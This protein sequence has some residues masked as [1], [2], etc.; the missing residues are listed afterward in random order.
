MKNPHGPGG[1]AG[2]KVVKSLSNAIEFTSPDPVKQVRRRQQ[3]ERQLQVALIE[4]LSWRAPAGTWWTHFPAGGRRS[5]VTGAIL[6]GMGTKPGCPDLFILSH[7][8]LYG[9]ELK[10]GRN[11][12][13]PAQ[14]ATHEEMRKAG[15]TIGTAGTLDQALDLLGAW[16]VIR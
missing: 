3:P 4:H 2:M 5:R 16:G 10:A 7:G 1:A 15:A 6:R 13:S 14:I 8:R 12:L 11:G 9:L